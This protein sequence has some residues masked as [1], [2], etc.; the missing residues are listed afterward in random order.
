MLL[1]AAIRTGAPA[2]LVNVLNESVW[3]RVCDMREDPVLGQ[4]IGWDGSWYRKRYPDV[5]AACKRGEWA[6]PLLHYLSFGRVEG[7]FPSASAEERAQRGEPW[8]AIFDEAPVQVGDLSVP[9]NWPVQ[10]EP[11]K[12]FL[13]K[14]TNGF[15]ERFLS[16]PVVLDIGYK[17]AAPDDAV[18]ILPH[19]I[20][21]DL[22]YPGY[23]GLRLPFADGAVDTI[24]ASHV[25]EHILDYRSV[26]RDWYRTL[27]AGGFIVCIVP[28][29]WLYEKKPDLP[30]RWNEDHKRFYTPASLLREF[31]ES[32]PSNGYRIRHLVDNDLGYLYEIGP[33]QH[34][35]GCYEIE[36]VVEKIEAPSWDLS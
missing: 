31:E 21:V 11:S 10:G 20:G 23:D 35:A 8:Q 22:D 12:T 19:A 15:F 34:A 28:H 24:F 7:R 4:P 5:E 17:G 30:S 29:H 25:L 3:A 6:D 1:E 18:P 26:L 9:L 13:L 33:Q 36:L 32:L 27:R 14:L 2:K 16:G